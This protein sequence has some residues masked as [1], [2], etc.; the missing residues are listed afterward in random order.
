MMRGIPCGTPH[1]EIGSGNVPALIFSMF[2]LYIASYASVSGGYSRTPGSPARPFCG[3][4]LA[5]SKTVGP[6]IC[7]TPLQSGSAA[8]EAGLLACP[9]AIP[10]AR[11]QAATARSAVLIAH[12]LNGPGS[13]SEDSNFAH[14]K[15]PVP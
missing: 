8:L 2:F 14:F 13:F 3:C 7:Q 5:R 15:N 9:A 6:T 10:M 12:P 4:T 11:T 1:T